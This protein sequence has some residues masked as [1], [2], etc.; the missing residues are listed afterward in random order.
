MENHKH[1]GQTGTLVLNQR[2]P[3]AGMAHPDN[4]GQSSACV[5]FAISKAIANLLFTKK[6][7]DVEQREIMNCLVQA[8]Q[9]ICAIS[10]FAYKDMVLFLQDSVNEAKDS[11]G[12]TY[13][14]KNWW[15][16]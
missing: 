7:I 9:S 4:Q 6:R 14:N 3:P 16:V 5:R 13:P 12:K 15:Q 2:I 10:P 1:N 11:N 8:K